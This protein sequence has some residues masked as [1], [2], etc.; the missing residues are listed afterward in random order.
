MYNIK[1]KVYVKHLNKFA[2]HNGPSILIDGGKFSEMY[3]PEESE[4]IFRY[5]TFQ[6]MLDGEYNGNITKFWK[7]INSINKL[8]IYTDNSYD[9]ILSYI[10][11]ELGHTFNISSN[12]IK[13]I[14]SLHEI[15]EFISEDNI[16]EYNN[17]ISDE[18]ITTGELYN[19]KNIQEL[20]IEYIA[21]MHNK[22]ISDTQ[23]NIKL[24]P[25]SKLMLEDFIKSMLN[26]VKNLVIHN[27]IILQKYFNDNSIV[28]SM[29]IK[30]SIKSDNFLTNFLVKCLVDMDNSLED[31]DKIF[32]VVFE[33]ENQEDDHYE[34]F[35]KFVDLYKNPDMNVFKDWIPYL[36]NFNFFVY[37]YNKFNTFILKETL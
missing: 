18:Y 13:K 19:T 32:K 36:I 9:L 31:I 27:P 33:F 15:N 30:E 17:L 1:N 11:S 22:Y 2:P 6:E 21:I 3:F 4:V 28:T 20:S 37:R 5:D 35:L 23:A 24:L 10:L 34:E 7:F 25:I 29:D 16:V 12:D 26:H 14:S 8:R